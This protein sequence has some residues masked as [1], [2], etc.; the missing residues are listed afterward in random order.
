[1]NGQDPNVQ[2]GE[3]REYCQRRGFEIAEEFVDK[4]ISGSR[5]APIRCARINSFMNG[6]EVDVQG[7]EP[8]E[9]VHQLPKASR[10]PV[11]AIDTVARVAQQI[12]SSRAAVPNAVSN[13]GYCLRT[14]LHGH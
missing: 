1:M 11:V 10:E 5:E 14:N 6:N 2:L 3:L 4:G 8:F 12:S 7:T 13:S 9:C